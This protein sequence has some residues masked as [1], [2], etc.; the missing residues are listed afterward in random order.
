M[1][2]RD[3]GYDGL[4]DRER[5]SHFLGAARA[6]AA[7]ELGRLLMQCRDYL[8][9]VADR[10]LGDD[11]KG[12]VN[13]SDLVQETFLEAKRDFERF[14]GTSGPEL[15]AW[16]CRIQRNN[17]LNLTRSFRDAQMRSVGREVA[18]TGAW[19]EAALACDTPSP[20]ERV[21]AG[22]EAAALSAGLERLPERY[23]QVLRFRYEHGMTFSQIG[24]ALDCTPEA[25]RKLWARAVDRLQR[26]L[27]PHE[28]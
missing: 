6:G 18:F 21:S 14:Q 9:L 28:P 15:L 12:K 26:E 13:P 5:F 22:E 3:L 4:S 2:E 8:L 20:S 11:L 1:S 23:Q 27:S 17:L 16:L 10:E 7:D 19:S 24:A 25:A